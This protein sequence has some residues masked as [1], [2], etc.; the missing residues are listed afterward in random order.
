MRQVDELELRRRLIA[1]Q[2]RL[3]TLERLQEEVENSAEALKEVRAESQ[4]LR[5]EV[6]HLNGSRVLRLARHLSAARHDPKR[7]LAWPGIA[8]RLLKRKF[9]RDQAL[10]AKSAVH[11]HPLFTATEAPDDLF[12]RSKLGEP[13]LGLSGEVFE[14]ERADDLPASPECLRLALISDRFTADSLAMECHTVHLHPERWLEQ[15]R[16]FRPHLLLV[17][18]A[19][20]GVAG[21]WQGKVAEPDETLCALVLSCR[22]AGIPTVFWNKEDPLHFEAFLRTA[23]L[24][25]QV[26]TTDAGSVIRYRERLGHEQVDCLP[27]A[28]QPRLHHPFLKPGQSRCEGSFFAGAWYPNLQERCRDF[29]ALADALALA[30][31]LVIHDRN[32][33]GGGS[34]YPHQYASLV[35]DAVPYEQTGELYRSYRIGLTL[36]TIKQSPTMFARRAMELACTNTSVY[37][38]YSQGLAMLM[39]DLVRMTDDGPAMFEWAWQELHDADAPVHRLR[40]LAALRKVMA[41][42]TWKKRLE[43]IA[44]RLLGGEFGQ[45]A[46]VVVLSRANSQAE[47]DSLV[48]MIRGQSQAVRLAIPARDGLDVPDE[49]Q[50]LDQKQCALS[51]GELFASSW[52]ALWHPADRYGE[53]YLSDMVAAAGFGQGEVIGKACYWT[54][55]EGGEQWAGDGLEYRIVDSLAWRRS[56]APAA[57]WERSIAELLAMIDEG[58]FTGEGLVSVDRDSYACATELPQVWCP[59]D[60]GLPLDALCD[61]LGIGLVERGRQISGARLA[62]LFDPAHLPAGVSLAARHGSMELVSRLKAG[63]AIRLVSSSLPWSVFADSSHVPALCLRCELERDLDVSIEFQGPAGQVT[64]AYRLL[65]HTHLRPVVPAGTAACRFVLDVRGKQVSYLAGVDVDASPE[66]LLLPGDGRLLV[67][68]NGYP[69]RDDLYRNAFV[70]RRVKLYQQR[71]V[72]VDVVWVCDWLPRHSYEYDGVRVQVCDADTLAAS[73]QHS[74]HKAIAVHFLD[75]MLWSAVREAAARIRTVVWIHGA[76]A[77]AWQRRAFLYETDEERVLA[78]EQSDRRMAFWREIF[79][80]RTETL[81]FVFVSRTQAKEVMD[82]VGMVLPESVWTVIHNPIDTGLFAY[83]EKSADD[84]FRILSIRPHASRVYANDLVAAT[85]RELSSR[86]GFERFSFTLVGDGPRWDEDFA[87]LDAF[88]N[89]TLKRGFIT[90]QEIKNLHDSH[91]VFLVP[92]RADT[93]G[94]SRDEAMASGLVPVTTAMGAVPE[95]VDDECGRACTSGDPVAMADVILQLAGGEH[96]FFGLS[97]AAAERVR[98]QS[99]SKAIITRELDMVGLS[100]VHHPNDKDSNED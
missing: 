18:S 50:V 59:F 42:H 38:N 34:N 88:P 61:G 89:V 71:G 33:Q 21:E 82:D 19:W 3:R 70:H 24:F 53:F 25:D 5:S 40:R 8:M 81:S 74:R 91:G 1:M 65:P 57:R 85:I 54:A 30:G 62:A 63:E 37:S 87:G 73:L 12:I 90:Q 13:G 93:Q 55:G 97:K 99:G 9:K 35:R 23:A 10:Q 77:Q 16:Q 68:A 52:V 28:V 27:F 48:E 60:P 67:V 80:Q 32:G 2:S 92:T 26:F 100:C 76:E 86:E 41:E 69:R 39:G 29:M 83:R 84:R 66:P 36:N 78:Q 51:P 44:G 17:E 15:M 95:F 64:A 14:L 22:A 20:Q 31:P 98:S 45:S 96:L 47:L 11:S 56:V 79:E 94:V 75:P 58:A 4:R 72:A 46:D 6:L 7:L 49:V 43:M